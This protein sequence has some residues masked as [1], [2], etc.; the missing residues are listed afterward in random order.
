MISHG[1]VFSEGS[2]EDSK[3]PIG[4]TSG[5]DLGNSQFWPLTRIS[6]SRDHPQ[7]IWI[8]HN[9]SGFLLLLYKCTDLRFVPSSGDASSPLSQEH[10]HHGWIYQTRRI[11][12]FNLASNNPL[13]LENSTSLLL[14]PLNYILNGSS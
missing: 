10:S 11:I 3:T 2:L 5:V 14:Q 1:Q 13:V 9:L 7:G 8:F 6:R 4:G 12:R